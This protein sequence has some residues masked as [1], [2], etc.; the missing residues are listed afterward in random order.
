MPIP[1]FS[2]ASSSE[3]LKQLSKQTHTL[4]QQL[5]VPL[6]VTSG[7]GKIVF[8]NPACCALLCTS[9][10]EMIGTEVKKWGLPAGEVSPLAQQLEGTPFTSSLITT[11]EVVFPATVRVR[12]LPDTSLFLFTLEKQSAVSSSFG[13]V[14]KN[15]LQ[16]YP[17]AV[18]FQEPQG[19]CVF[20]NKQTEKLFGFKAD[21]IINKTVYSFLPK[22]IVPSLKHLDETTRE[23]GSL[24]SA[25][26]SYKDGQNVERILEVNKVFVPE[27]DG[28]RNL[29]LT[30]FVD[31]T[32][33]QR[34]MAELLQTRA[35]LN[36]VLDNIPLGLYTRDSDH[37]LTFFNR[38]SQKILNEENVEMMR[39]AHHF[40][41]E[42]ESQEIRERELQILR[43]GKIRDFPAEEYTDSS[44]NKKILH[45]IKVPLK[46]A[47]PKPLVLSIM[48]DIT[49]RHYQ[50]KEIKRINSILSA[51]VQNVPVALYARDD[52]GTLILR[53]KQCEKIFN[54]QAL[55]K[56]NNKGVL[57]HETPEQVAEYLKREK[58][59]LDRKEILDIP[60]E[61]YITGTGDKKVL[62]LIKVPVFAEGNFVLTLVEDITLRKEQEKTIL[63]TRNFLQTV[64]DN[65]PVSV[66]VKDYDG[67]YILWNKKS[68]EVFGVKAEKVIGETSYRSDLNKEQ[69]EFI[70]ETDL[71]VFNSRKEQNIPQELISS[72]KE[73]VKIM[74]TVRTPIFRTDGVTPQY[75][76]NV[77]E[78]ITA[79]TRMEKRIR[80]ASDK[81][82][83]LLDNA[84]EGVLIAEDKKIIYA[85]RALCRMLGYERV[86]ALYNRSLDEFVAEDFRLFFNEQY[87]AARLGTDEGKKVSTFR[88]IQAN[89]KEIEAEFSAVPSRYLG[90]RIVLC[91]LRDV[92][93]LLRT[94]R[95]LKQENEDFRMAFEENITPCF[96]LQHNGYIHYMNKAGRELFGFTKEDSKFYRNIY[97]RPAITRAC[98]QLLKEGKN[99]QMEYVLDFDKASQKF[100]RYIHKTGTLSLKVD[101]IPFHKRDTKEGVEADYIVFLTPL[102]K[103]QEPPTATPAPVQLHHE[104]QPENT[105]KQTPPE[106]L[107]ILPNSE[108]YALCSSDWKMQLCNPLFC[109]LCQLK[110][111]ELIGKDIRYIIDE[112][113]R[114]QFE[115][116]LRT[117]EETGTLS[118][119]DYN[120]PIAN[121]LEKNSIRLMGVREPDGRYLFVLRNMTFHRQIMRI[122]EERS[123][124]LNALLDSMD[125]I[126]FSVSVKNGTFG[127]IA[128][129]NQFLVRKLG[130][131]QDE[132]L[133]KQFRE[134][135]ENTEEKQIDLLLR[136]LEKEL[137]EKGK[138]AF[139]WNMLRK[140][141][142][143]FEARVTVTLLDLPNQETA[144]VVVQDL[145]QKKRD[146][147]KESKEALELKSIREALPGLYIKVNREGKVVE[148][149]SNLT[150]WDS[151]QAAE[152][153]IGKKL[154]EI[155]PQET[156]AL[157]MSCLKESLSVNVGTH[158]DVTWEL[159]GKK[160][161]FEVQIS[162]IAGR[163][164]AVLWVTDVSA[165]K[166][167][168]E[169]LHQLYQ[170]TSNPHLSL[171]EQVEKILQFGRESF[172]MD[173]GF[174]IRF[175][176]FEKTAETYVLYATENDFHLE[177]GMSFVLQECLQGVLEGNVI[178]WENLEG[179]D[180]T[181]CVHIKKGFNSLLAAPL[182]VNGSVMGALCFAATQPVT[183]FVQGAEELI[184]ILA[185]LLGLRIE[186][187]Q[188]CKILDE[189]SRS[190]IRTLEYVDKPVVMFDLQYRIT[191]VNRSFV[192][193]TGRH[194][195]NLIGRNFF[196]E[197]AREEDLSLDRFLYARE[198]ADENMFH[199]QLDFYHRNRL[200]GDTGFQVVMCKDAE[201]QVVA[202]ALIITDD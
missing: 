6:L 129:V 99:A 94:Q 39:Q 52:E 141:G 66:S 139:T 151:G 79:K 107:L 74:H 53:N 137:A 198:N 167:Y 95:V 11:Q 113:S 75:L 161:Y 71:R 41:S 68:E 144:L 140:E 148:V 156:G 31:A 196:D 90:R 181:D 160:H 135:F 119:R 21:D 62:H 184:G 102:T 158:F 154:T 165:D 123:A 176:Q 84:R 65:L 124:Q 162:P 97:I 24:T 104:P 64:I 191:Y 85:N 190:V 22:E 83:L 76:L 80:E 153:L 3:G 51:I 202:Y 13:N 111:E 166:E 33:H 82:T 50:E 174:V 187:R 188:T 4:L 173:V 25:Q 112:E 46:D 121:G 128:H 108:P 178:L 182:Y 54:E 117:L 163:E 27:A 1:F 186:L 105:G 92:T 189:A 115:E 179:C 109:S 86:E 91:C 116:D 118:H 110:K 89:G 185:R 164:E 8:C 93:D 150:F 146:F 12:A 40:Q 138:V 130:F 49:E 29:I 175:E 168:D 172:K 32:E 43:E 67:K 197:L 16:A 131:S 88:W 125:G 169:Q 120:L 42:Q 69:A 9:T 45:L 55:K 170:F 60:E 15:A 147:S 159:V 5:S 126:V 34:E 142:T 145:S 2:K 98:R 17:Q 59:I 56:A 199:V 192:E 100:P 149:V 127:L 200:Y 180:C 44:G 7:T 183:E 70:R 155:W 47:G 78:D 19:T 37:Q 201:G 63:E 81:N 72:S 14:L 57:P 20:C 61:E 106:E 36:A 132:L 134:L 35:L 96:I 101:F 114:T 171:T 26:L 38:Q 152:A 103:E 10:E 157:A 28:Q 177:K 195:E 122:L 23:P 58:A 48:D 136:S 193:I 133:L 87:E 143:P 77:S 194:M 73:G 30:V 18:M